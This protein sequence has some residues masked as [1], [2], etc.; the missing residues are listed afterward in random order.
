VSQGADENRLWK[1]CF[2]AGLLTLV[3]GIIV[4]AVYPSGGGD[5][6]AGY[7]S[8]IIALEFAQTA[9]QAQAV[10]DWGSDAASAYKAAMFRG[11]LLDMVFLIIYGL[12][13]ASFFQAAHKQTGLS[14]YRVMIGIAVIAACA[15]MV[16]NFFLFEFLVDPEATDS[17]GQLWWHYFVKTK[18]TA[19]GA[20]GLGAGFFLLR[21]PRILRKIE[22]A[23]AGLGGAL[24]LFAL[25]QPENLGNALG[26]GVTLSWLAML[27]YA[28][29]QA[30]KKARQ[31]PI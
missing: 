20:A 12:F 30:A 16:E 18:F 26:L 10:I 14:I 6:A 4:L 2:I 13:L 28:A 11:T 3:L 27:A 8:P 29:T 25:T 15:D 17:S 24:T 19:L 9:A 1:R 5:Y 22:G 31:K 21:Q 23:F 7:G